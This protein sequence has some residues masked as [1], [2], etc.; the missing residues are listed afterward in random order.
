MPKNKRA[1]RPRVW[2]YQDEIELLAYLDFTLEH[3]L[4][5]TSTVS[6]HL[7]T[8]TGKQFS[9]K[10]VFGKLKR[11]WSK[12]GRNG[13]EVRSDQDLLSE[14]SSFLVEWTESDHEEVLQA[15]RRLQPPPRRYRLRSTPRAT[16]ATSRALSRSATR[17]SSDTSPLSEHGTPEFNDFIEREN[18]ATCK[19]CSVFGTRISSITALLRLSA[20]TLCR[21]VWH[22]RLSALPHL[23]A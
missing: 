22:R 4:D 17:Q 1:A 8:V 16:I 15:L 19:V 13:G 23:K 18:G 3:K 9:E 12:C 21:W 11:A 14:G 7:A 2:E 20:L 5:F 6:S 10:Q